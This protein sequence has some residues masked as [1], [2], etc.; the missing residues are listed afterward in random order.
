MEKLIARLQELT[1]RKQRFTYDLRSDCLVY[2]GIVSAY[3][4]TMDSEHFADL[5]AVVEHAQQHDGIIGGW[6]DPLDGRLNLDSC[7]LFTDVAGALRFAQHEGQ[8]SVYNLNREEEVH[9]EAKVIAA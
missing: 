6:R 5:A 1:V 7:R 3:R 9:V 8:R 4:A 2:S